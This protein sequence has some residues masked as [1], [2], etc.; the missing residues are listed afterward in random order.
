MRYLR[1]EVGHLK[2]K[3]SPLCAPRLLIIFSL[4]G[5]FLKYKNVFVFVPYNSNGGV[6]PTPRRQVWVILVQIYIYMNILGNFE[7]KNY[8]YNLKHLARHAWFN[9]FGMDVASKGKI[10]G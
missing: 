9:L 6:C 4:R 5:K 10:G 8:Y 7:K 2:H 1:K 3:K